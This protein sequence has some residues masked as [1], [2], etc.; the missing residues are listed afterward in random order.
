M[1]DS[2][3]VQEWFTSQPIETWEIVGL[4]VLG[5]LALNLMR[6]AWFVARYVVFPALRI[7]RHVLALILVPR[8]PR[9][10]GAT[11]IG[12]PV[13]LAE[14]RIKRAFPQWPA[15]LKLAVH[16]GE[17]PGSRLL[18]VTVEEGNT[19]QRREWV[20]SVRR[21]KRAVR[22]WLAEYREVQALLAETRTSK[23]DVSAAFAITITDSAAITITDSAGT[24][25][26]QDAQT[27]AKLAP[28]IGA[29]YEGHEIVGATDETLALKTKAGTM[30]VRRNDA[31]AP[32]GAPWTIP[33]EGNR[34]VS[35]SFRDWLTRTYN[36]KVASKI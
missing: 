23:P 2:Q 14:R 16:P 30:T 15:A 11:D 5:L 26:R 34:P 28:M 21:A 20:K 29:S 6:P 1:F 13:R 31:T 27:R 33:A 12:T 36:E 19:W 8:L 7:T 18:Y 10:L 24:V 35:P 22:R 4:V 17:E 25:V 3:Q 9:A 32:H